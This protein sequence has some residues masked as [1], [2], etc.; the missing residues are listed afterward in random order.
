MWLPSIHTILNSREQPQFRYRLSSTYSFGQYIFHYGIYSSSRTSSLSPWVS[1]FRHPSCFYT[2]HYVWGPN[3][4]CDNFLLEVKIDSVGYRGTVTNLALQWLF[5]GHR[6][7]LFHFLLTQYCESR[8]IYMFSQQVRK[9]TSPLITKKALK[10]LHLGFTVND[11]L[12]NMARARALRCTS[13]FSHTLKVTNIM[14]IFKLW[15]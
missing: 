12:E 9:S 14:G 3:L 4:N 8:R 5:Q 13:H 10:P 2:A 6:S 15:R 7:A 1:Q 11:G